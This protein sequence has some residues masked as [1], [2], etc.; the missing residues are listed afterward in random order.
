MSINI[1]ISGADRA[2]LK[3]LE[4]EYAKILSYD[5]KTVTVTVVQSEPD[6]GGMP[7]LIQ[8]PAV[9]RALVRNMLKEADSA[10]SPWYRKSPVGEPFPSRINEADEI[11]KGYEAAPHTRIYTD[12]ESYIR[13]NFDYL[14]AK[15][16][17]T[18]GT[19][20]DF[21]RASLIRR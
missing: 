3:R 7:P 6:Y 17:Y 13:A 16:G 2:A 18:R 21:F 11:L 12:R 4:R 20:E 9:R 19:V 10:I 14:N 5:G 8:T 15:F 1:T